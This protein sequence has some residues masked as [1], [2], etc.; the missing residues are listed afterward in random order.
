[1]VNFED[2]LGDDEAAVIDPRD[3]FLTLNRD[4]RFAFPRDIQTEVMK[5]WFKLRDQRDTVIK[6]NVGSGKTL[7]GLLLLQSSLNEDAGPALY[8]CPD[9]Q[10]VSQVTEEAIALGLEV[11]DDPRDAAFA[12]GQKICVTTV[13]KLFNGRSVFGVENVKLSIGT[14]IVDDA[15]ASIATIA[16]QFRITLPNT[17]EAY[18]KIL[19]TVAGDLK[20]Q[21]HSRFL[22]LEASDPRA[23]MEVPF[24]AWKDK[25][26]NIL[27]SLHEAKDNNELKFSYPLLH[28]ILPYCRCFI[29]GQ[30]LE[31]EPICPPTDLIRSFFKA[32]R[33]IY[34]TATLSDDSV[35][36][37]HFGAN[38]KKLPD[39]IVP[40]SSQFMGERMILMPQELN[41]DIE[42]P[43]IRKMLADISKKENVVV[44][45]PSKA[46]SDNWEKVADQIL[47]G[48]KVTPGIDK[49]R[50]GHV[51]LTVLVNR[52]DGIDLP[53]DACRVLALVDLP[54]V[55]S[56]REAADMN[57]LADSKAGLRR[58]MQRIEQGMGRG[59]RS[60]DD[61]CVVLLCGAK[62][63]SRIKSPEG[64]QML[65]GATQAQLELSTNLA[66][67]LD[68]TDIAGLK[69]V[70]KQC[71]E[72]DAGWV[73]VSKKALLKAKVGTGLSLDPIAVGVRTSFDLARIGDHPGAVETLKTL[74]NSLND[75]DAKALILVREAEVAHH[76]DPAN[77][78]KI[79]LAAHKL[80]QSVL[81]PIEGIAYQKLTPVAGKQ[82]AAVQEIHRSRFLEA[83]DRILHFKSLVDDLKF[84]PDTNNEFEGAIIE[85]GRLIGIGSQ[86]PEIAFGKGPD[87]LLAFSNGDFI[88]IECKNGATSEQGISKH[89]LGQLGQAIDW[90]EEKYTKTVTKTALIIHPLKHI[91]PG[92]A[93]I[94]GARV[95]TEKQLV[96]LRTALLD[97]AKALGDGNVLNDVTRIGQL[98][99]THSLTPTSFLQQYSVPLKHNKEV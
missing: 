37:T 42:L 65:T 85:M 34:M 35:L 46:T 15:H 32:K 74:A 51:G 44:I 14:V 7:V 58:Q 23:I 71:L 63:T 21:S 59:V 12:A 47:I 41:P 96:K 27:K 6:L 13:H 64:R 72:R 45:V 91:G 48:D 5:A 22:S 87:N 57:I 8:I 61:Y 3:I 62:L 70:I 24:W 25:Q 94:E 4:K 76:I 17:H 84:E 38:P 31:I 98:L 54:E 75:D 53:G 69:K 26:E 50:A 56:F 88:V 10:L 1:M 86:R 36:I 89:D 67:Q 16:D 40:V 43:D 77:A 29:G 52:Y 60:N 9:H 81:K 80:N 95:M 18:G 83:A 28:E 2:L 20:K 39:P 33:R 73:K 82:A 66:K 90:F 99:T 19:K 78:Q 97:F 93:M 79:L 68:G 30:S 55:S 92:A 11:V 49:L